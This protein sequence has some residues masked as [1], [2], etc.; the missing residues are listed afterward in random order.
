MKKTKCK[1]TP[2]SSM[3]SKILIG[4]V[5]KL[6]VDMHENSYVVSAKIDGSAPLRSKRM[7]P[8]D[9]FGFVASILP[10]FVRL[11]CCYE[12]GCFGYQAH[13]RL[14]SLGVTNYV[15]RPINL[16]RFSKRVKTDNGDA[17]QLALYLD[18]YVQGN[19]RSFSAV[20]VPSEEQEQAR[21]VTRH[22]EMLMRERKR[23]AAVGSGNA[24]YY[25]CEA[26]GA[27]YGKRG[28]AELEKTLPEHLLRLLR[29]LRSIILEIQEQI[30]ATEKRMQAMPIEALPKG[31]GVTLYQQLEREAGDWRRFANRKRIGSYVGLCPCED[32]SAD[33][34][35]QGSINKSG[36]PR[37]RRLFVE[38]VWL[39]MK[40]NPGYKGFDKWSEKLLDAESNKASKK[41]IVV[42]IARQLAVDWWRVRTGRIKPE[43]L[44]LEMKTA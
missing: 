22:R 36:N 21:S 25:G 26:K 37:M 43:D 19:E 8:Q 38:W 29:S 11:Y 3:M 12:V 28:F 16:D 44:G 2:M 1:Y 23:L 15:I 31:M 6:G 18:G 5:I 39:L 30:K 33:R 24:R 10:K 34:R 42:A 13:R 17:K 35:R 40:W 14:V 20:T 7:S 4:V 32:S 41:K 9:F 27:W